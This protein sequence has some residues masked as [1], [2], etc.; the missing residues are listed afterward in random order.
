MRPCWP[1]SKAPSCAV[2][3]LIAASA[4]PCSPLETD[5]SG[6]VGEASMGSVDFVDCPFLGHR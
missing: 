5:A 3:V 6:T 1:A 2:P 4:P